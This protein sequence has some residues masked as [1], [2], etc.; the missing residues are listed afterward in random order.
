MEDFIVLQVDD[1]TYVYAIDEVDIDD[2]DSFQKIRPQ[3]VPSKTD[4][5]GK[6]NPIK[7]YH[8]IGAEIVEIK[9]LRNN[10][11][12]NTDS[13]AKFV[14]HHPGR[15]NDAIIGNQYSKQIG[16]GIPEPYIIV[17]DNNDNDKG[18]YLRKQKHETTNHQLLSEVSSPQFHRRQSSLPTTGVIKNLV[19]LLQFN[20]HEKARRN[21]PPQEEIEHLMASLTSVYLENSL[22]KLMIESTIVPE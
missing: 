10:T 5:V 6:L 22:G 12:S 11:S 15:L 20:D 2:I 18:R 8:E 3:L 1:G 14:R 19:I 17:G 16:G 4:V 7:Y 9:S 13:I 21:L